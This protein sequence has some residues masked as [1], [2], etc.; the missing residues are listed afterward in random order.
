[1]SFSNTLNLHLTYTQK[2]RFMNKEVRESSRFFVV[3]PR[4]FRLSVWRGFTDFLI[5]KYLHLST[6]RIIS[7]ETT[8]IQ[9]KFKII[10]AASLVVVEKVR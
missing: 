3:P 8:K 10:R 9:H 1:M 7:S 5:H 4:A 2:S 6:L